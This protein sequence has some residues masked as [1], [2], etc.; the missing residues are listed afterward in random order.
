MLA[1]DDWIE[2]ERNQV[3]FA[4]YSLIMLLPQSREKMPAPGCAEQM[5]SCDMFYD[6][7]TSC[8]DRFTNTCDI[9]TCYDE[10]AFIRAIVEYVR[11][12]YCL[13]VNSVHM[14]GS[15]NGGMLAYSSLNRP[16]IFS[17]DHKRL[18]SRLQ[19]APSFSN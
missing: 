11:N 18:H 3:W 14:S 1:D 17:L 15:S 10:V 13:D 16:D 8:Q 4:L 9:R 2:N 19:V 5:G 12:S 6:E 7:N